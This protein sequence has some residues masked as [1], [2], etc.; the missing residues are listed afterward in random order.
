[1]A[2]FYRATAY[3]VKYTRY[4]G[5]GESALFKG[6]LK[7]NR[8][9]VH[10]QKLECYLHMKKRMGTRCRNLKQ[11]TKGLG[12]RN[13]NTV[14]LTD[15]VFNELQK[16]YGLAIIR[17][18]DNFDKMY[19]EI[20][21]TLHHLSSTDENP[22]YGNCPADA[23]S[24]CLYR[25]AEAEGMDVSKFKHDY[26]SLDKDITKALEPIYTDWS[27]RELLERCKRG[28][29]LNNTESYNGW[30]FAPKH[31]HN[32]LKTIELAN[33]LAVSMFKDGF[34]AV[35]K[36]LQVMDVII[37]PITKEYAMDRADRRISQA[38]LRHKASSKEGQKL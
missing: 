36:M 25:R 11:Q 27:S 21:A 29:T 5:N 9:D 4:I 1:M 19:K 17:H 18:Q 7:L 37:G 2:A 12:G 8:Y 31:L 32:G 6:F 15:K 14:K 10:V 34:C 20:W 23:N 33:F 28:N 16:Y 30:H 26:L 22:T 13:K 24:W 35:L 38:K 3:G